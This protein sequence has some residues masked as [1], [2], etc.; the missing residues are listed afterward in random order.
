MYL[1]PS[2]TMRTTSITVTHNTINGKCGFC[3]NL[4]VRMTGFTMRF[5]GWPLTF[6][7]WKLSMSS[8]LS[9]IFR[10]RENRAKSPD[11]WDQDIQLL[12]WTFVLVVHPSN[13]SRSA[14]DSIGA[15]LMSV[16]RSMGHLPHHPPLPCRYD[17][18]RHEDIASTQN[19]SM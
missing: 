3:G 2:M 6:L 7:L 16:I 12:T 9:R 15:S 11:C 1:T 5:H 13:A 17:T 8:R 19:S 4:P 14:S 18:R 10:K